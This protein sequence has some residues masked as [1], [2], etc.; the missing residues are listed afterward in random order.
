MLNSE[1]FSLINFF[2]PTALGCILGV[3]AL[4]GIREFIKEALFAFKKE[5]HA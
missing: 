3:F 2:I 5:S 4:V 1:S